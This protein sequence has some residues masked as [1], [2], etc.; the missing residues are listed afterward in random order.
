MKAC[1]NSL[2]ELVLVQKSRLLSDHDG[3]VKEEWQDLG[4]LWVKREILQPI[5]RRVGRITRGYRLR[6]QYLEEPIY[7]F[8][9]RRDI[10][11]KAGMRLKGARASY[12][13]LEDGQGMI[14][15][16]W[17]QFCGISLKA[18]ERG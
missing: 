13:V 10:P 1:L 11:I 16:G 17:Q 15:R 3:G 12:A 9:A 18:H 8:S 5:R 2:Q 4:R 14:S 6:A 7:V